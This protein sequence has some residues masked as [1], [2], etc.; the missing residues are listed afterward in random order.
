MGPALLAQMANEYTDYAAIS[1]N[2][3]DLITKQFHYLMALPMER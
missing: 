2:D 3:W 1:D